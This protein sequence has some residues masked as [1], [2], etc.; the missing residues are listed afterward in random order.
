M[1]TGYSTPI[2]AW[3]G[4]GHELRFG[5]CF[6]L[7]PCM[8][9]ALSKRRFTVCV[10]AHTLDMFLKNFPTGRKNRCMGTIS[11]MAKAIVPYIKGL[12]KSRHDETSY[13]DTQH[14]MHPYVPE[15]QSLSCMGL[16]LC[17]LMYSYRPKTN[18]VVMYLIP[19]S[20]ISRAVMLRMATA[21]V[22]GTT[23]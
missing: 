15:R 7:S 3:K 18:L 2:H 4:S 14:T 5:H 13:G 9:L 1:L 20:R 16:C 17:T 22:A 23:K 6:V 12:V 21:S 11:Q 8:F 10:G 19:R